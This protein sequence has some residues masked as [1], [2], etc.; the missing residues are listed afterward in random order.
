MI[1]A[2]DAWN[3]LVTVLWGKSGTSVN[4]DLLF[5]FAARAFHNHRDIGLV[6]HCWVPVRRILSLGA[7]SFIRSRSQT[8][9]SFLLNRARICAGVNVFGVPEITVTPYIGGAAILQASPLLG[10]V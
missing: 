7:G 9:G 6:G 5:G 8:D 10:F 4:V 1:A 2:S 3:R